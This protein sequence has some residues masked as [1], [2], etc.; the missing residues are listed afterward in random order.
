MTAS[1]RPLDGRAALITGGGSGIGLACARWLLR[2][3]ASVTL[4]GRSEQRLRGAAD[5][6]EAD[7]SE[8]AT[9]RWAVCDV[10]R[11]A[12]V[13]EAVAIACESTG[14]LTIAVAS[15]GTGTIGPVIATP[16]EAWE[17]V[18]ATNLT[19]AFVTIKHAGAAIARSGGGAIVAISSIAAPLT[20][21]YMAAY[22]V[23]KAGLETLVRNAADELG[24]AGVRVN[25]VRPG[26][27][28]TELATP[29]VDDEKVEAD[30][31]AQMP[32]GRLGTVDDV[33]AGVRYLCGP[34]SSWVTGQCLAID[35]AGIRCGE[36]R[37]S[38]TG[39]ALC[40]AMGRSTDESPRTERFRQFERP[41]RVFKLHEI[42]EGLAG[43]H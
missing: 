8:G 39:P 25:A 12:D 34:E 36:G 40:M 29:L 11:E 13:A 32:L 4:A 16:I 10:A 42:R 37:T 17:L 9:V 43:F 27:V 31:L 22:C 30:Y 21:L 5:G 20:H 7:A 15:A 23:S 33:A 41:L 3:G 24:R 18:M 38:S 28:P 26:L 2:D 1:E 19:G 35:G 6:L 14:A